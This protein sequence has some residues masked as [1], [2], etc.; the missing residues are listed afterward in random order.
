L[1]SRLY[2]GCM[3]RLVAYTQKREAQSETYEVADIGLGKQI[4]YIGLGKTVTTWTTN[5]GATIRRNK[6]VKKV[7]PGEIARSIRKAP[8]SVRSMVACERRVSQKIMEKLR[9][10]PCDRNCRR[11]V[12]GTLRKQKVELAGKTEA[13]ELEAA[14]I[15]ASPG[16]RIPASLHY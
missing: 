2:N 11:G 6:K 16:L 1:A 5:D 15:Q 9:M 8:V 10:R 14:H 12:I 13:I 3:K 4:A 7:V